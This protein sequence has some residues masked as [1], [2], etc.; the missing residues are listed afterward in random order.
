MTL[1]KRL[2]IGFALALS[3]ILL[4][5]PANAD[6]EDIKA[7][8][9]SVV[10]VALIAMQGEQVFFLGHGSGFAVTPNIIVTNAHVVQP[11]T[12]DRSIIIG[13]VPSE[14]SEIYRAKIIAYS[15]QKDLALIRIEEGNLEPISIFGPQVNDGDEIVAIGYPGAVDRALGLTDGDKVE[16]GR[17]V[18][19]TGTISGGRSNREF[20]TFL[21]TAAVA[22]GNS[23]GPIVDQCGRVVGVNSFISVSDG[24]DAE[25]GFAI[26]NQELL[27]F[28]RASGITARIA[29]AACRS[30]AQISQAETR[31]ALAL[32]EQQGDEAMLRAQAQQQRQSALER[33]IDQDIRS[34]RENAMALAML[35]LV[36]GGFAGTAA[37]IFIDKPEPRLWRGCAAVGGIL[38]VGAAGLFLLRPS[39][40]EFSDRLAVAIAARSEPKQDNKPV[41]KGFAGDN[42]CLIDTERSR[43]TVSNISEMRFDWDEN[44]C[45]NGRT[46]YGRN[47]DQWLRILV[48]N[49]EQTISVNRFDPQ[50]GELTVS[51][52]LMG[53]EAMVQARKI[54]ASFTVNQCSNDQDMRKRLEDMQAALLD[55][56]PQRPNE[57]LVL[58]CEKQVNEAE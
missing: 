21:H 42:I 46:Q 51:R 9:R 4:V 45:V 25:F 30:S 38:A 31:R 50:N 17:P 49:D 48:P 57:R 39:Y 26:S 36:L 12:N 19:T 2:A 28:L 54:R 1:I 3:S 23:G 55:I 29:T 44:G 47:N 32:I 22:R 35:L 52:Y 8:S 10:R 33:S 13:V 34:E 5:Q 37:L 56:I 7:S 6:P 43:I 40:D 18:K 27:S 16:P 41:T 11:S 15:P 53:R 20:A 58:E 24:S 14:G